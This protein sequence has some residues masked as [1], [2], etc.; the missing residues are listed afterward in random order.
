MRPTSRSAAARSLRRGVGGQ[1]AQDQARRDRSRGQGGA[2]PQDVGPVR[3][4]QRL[5]QLA[6]DHAAQF[7]R[8]GGRLEDVDTLGGQVADARH[9]AVSQ[10]RG[11]GK[12]VVGEAA[13]VGVL[14]ADVAA[15]LVH[16]QAVEDIGRL[17]DGCG[18]DLGREGSE[19]VRDVGVGLEAGLV[20]VP[21]ID[22]VHGFPL[23]RGREELAI[24][25]RGSP[26]TPE[27]RHGQS[28]LCVDYH[29]QRAGKS[30]A[31]HMPARQP[32]EF[33]VVVGVWWNRPSCRG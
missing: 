26:R 19:A 29:F 14:F 12:D 24:A 3:G 21:G 2:Q 8:A 30:L 9:E 28:G 7:L 5:A 15:G 4:D 10:D 17:V 18:D 22:Q 33:P 6:A 25:R 13:G 11:D 27:R 23:A 31:F 1:L 16:Q 32:H 20:S